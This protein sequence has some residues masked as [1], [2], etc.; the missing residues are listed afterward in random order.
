ML[1]RP[2][3]WDDIV[4]PTLLRHVNLGFSETT[5]DTEPVKA[6]RNKAIVGLFFGRNSC[7]HCAP[8]LEDFRKLTALRSDTS[9]ILVPVRMARDESKRY[10]GELYD[11][12]S[13]PY[14]G[15]AGRTLV[16]R[17]QITTVPAIILLD[18]SGRVVCKDGRERIRTDRLGENFPWLSQPPSLHPVVHPPSA[19]FRALPPPPTGSLP[20]PPIPLPRHF[21]SG[22]P[23]AAPREPAGPALGSET[24]SCFQVQAGE[25]DVH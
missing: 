22:P 18:A 15:V 7:P 11:W 13:V 16:D 20:P 4:G 24:E 17:F 6:L 2:S 10:F 1:A 5:L 21:Q 9:V 19:R 3:C 12:L 23:I 14:D 25:I 8:V